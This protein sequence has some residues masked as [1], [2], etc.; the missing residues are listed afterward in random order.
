MIGTFAQQGAAALAKVTPQSGRRLAMLAGEGTLKPELIEIVTQ[1][2][3]AACEF[4][5]RNKGSLAAGTAFTAFVAAPGE[6]LDGTRKLVEPIAEVTLPPIAEVPGIVAAEAA[7]S[8]NWT[9]VSL[10]LIG[11]MTLVGYCRWW[12]VPLRSLGT[13]RY[14]RP[15]QP[16]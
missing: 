9:L 14:E 8:I 5:W 7:K 4:I 13:G 6:F 11:V 3:D 10:V 12:R 16:R 15:L 2:G 1:Y